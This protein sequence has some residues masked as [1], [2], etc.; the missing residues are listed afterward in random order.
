MIRRNR[1]SELHLP[2]LR[3]A[4]MFVEFDKKEKELTSIEKTYTLE[5]KIN[6]VNDP[7][8][9]I[10]RTKD[11]KLLIASKG[12]R[13][14]TSEIIQLTDEDDRPDRVKVQVVEANGVHVAVHGQKVNEFT[15][16]QLIDEVVSIVDEG[17]VEMGSIRLLARDG[18]SRS[19][20]LTVKTRSTQV[21][22]KLVS[23]TGLKLLHHSSATITKRNLS[24]EA[25]IR[26]MIVSYRIVDLPDTGVVECRVEGESEFSMCTSFSQS[27]INDEEVR[28][29][30]TS[31]ASSPSDMFS[32]Q[33]EAGEYASM[34]HVFRI[35]FIPMNVKVFTREPFVLN[36]TEVATIGRQN[37]FAWTFP[38]S[39]SSHNLIYFI[40]EPPKLGTLSRRIG[41]TKKQRRI[42]VSSNFTQQ[43]IDEGSISYKLHYQQYSIVND[44][45]MFRVVSPAVSSALLRFEIVY[46]PQA[47]S[48]RLINKTIVVKE[49]E[50]A[51]VTPD[52]LS[53]STPD[54]SDFV[55]RVITP[56]VHGTLRLRDAFLMTIL[57]KDSNFT[58]NDLMKHRLVYTHSDDESRSDECRLLAISSQNAQ[59]Q[60]PLILS[61]SIILLNDNAPSVSK[62]VTLYMVERGERVLHDFL[63]PWKDDDVDT[64]ALLFDFAQNKDAAILST[65]S[66]YLP[67]TSFSQHEID[68]GKVMIR[69]LG[70][71]SEFDIN[72]TVSDGVHRVDGRMHVV[73]E[74]PKVWVQH[75]EAIVTCG[76]TMPQIIRLTSKNLTVLTNLDVRL[77]DIV[78]S[79]NSTRF[80]IGANR[81]VVST[82]TQKDIDAELVWY[83]VASENELESLN[84]AIA[85]RHLDVQFVVRCVATQGAYDYQQHQVLRVPMGGATLID[86]TVLG[87]FLNEHLIYQVVRQPSNGYL[88]LDEKSFS[89]RVSRFTTSDVKN[90]R[91]QYVHNNAN[92]MNDSIDFQIQTQTNGI[93]LL[94]TLDID[95]FVRNVSMTTRPFTVPAG[96]RAP[97]TPE[98]LN[99]TTSENDEDAV[100]SVISPPT[101]GWITT[102]SLKNVSN[103]NSI[104]SFTS[105]MLA[106]GH[107]WF[108][109]DGSE[110][111]DSIAVRAC[112]QDQCTGAQLLQIIVN[113]INV[114]GPVLIR[115]EVL[116]V[117]GE[118]ALITNLHLNVKDEDTP[119]N[120]I[121]YLISPPSNGK[122]VKMPHTQEAITNFTQ[123]DI[124]QSHVVFLSS[125]NSNPFGGFSFH[126]SDGIQKIGPEWFST[127]LSSSSNI[128]EANGRLVASPDSAVV[129]G[130][131]LLRANMPGTKPEEIVFTILK[132]PKY[133]ELLIDGIKGNIFTQTQI[134]RRQVVYSTIGTIQ[135]NEWSRRDSFSF[136]I[137]RNNSKQALN[138]N[139]KFRITTT[140]AALSDKIISKY[141]TTS[142]L[143]VSRGGS[144][145]FNHSHLDVSSL[146]DTVDKEV[147]MI[148]IGTEPRH[149]RLEWLDNERKR[150]S[151]TE[152][153]SAFFL[154]YQHNDQDVGDDSLVFHVYAAR[155]STRRASRIRVSVMIK[156]RTPP[157]PNVQV[158]LFPSSVSILNS[159]STP[160]L[161]DMLMT[162]HKSVP[163][164]SIVYRTI[165][166]GANGVT[167]RKNDDEVKMFTQN[168]I[169]EG[170]IALWHTSSRHQS[171]SW[172]DV[173]VV[174]I[175]GHT[176]TIVVDIKP[177]DLT[178]KNHSTIWYPQGKT[179]VVLSSRHLGAFSNG[180]REM[181][182]YKITS[183]PENG[184]FYWVAGEKEAK[185]FT[186]KDI[187]E[188]RILYAQLNMHSYQDRFEFVVENDSRD[189]LR[190]SSQL[191]V[192]AL[193]AVQPVIVEADTATP[194]TSSQINASALMNSSPRFF[195]TS[196]LKYGRL[197]FDPNTNYTTYY[198]TYSDIQKGIV[199]YKA[200]K[201]D[202]E[203]HEI[204]NL[205]V[206]ADN[207]Q[208]ARFSLPITI[209]RA[210]LEPIE[211]ITT[212]EENEVGGERAKFA[213]FG[214]NSVP[215][216]ILGAILAATLFILLCRRCENDKKKKKKKKKT[217][218][219]LNTQL[220]TPT[221]LPPSPTASMERV[222]KPAD[223]LG[224]TVFASVRQAEDRM[225][226]QSFNK[227]P[228]SQEEVHRKPVGGVGA[229][230]RRQ[231]V[232][233]LDYAGIS[234]DTPPPMR[235]FDQVANTQPANHYWV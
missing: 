46:V 159:G 138:S 44:F 161:A 164:Q 187:D 148:E 40:D 151:W 105:K 68:E 229:V 176:R 133:G 183:G 231:N 93:P 112:V 38:K 234:S 175:E 191:M 177:L 145:C 196:Q 56:T 33:V 88:L 203:V 214:E 207:V 48:I 23:N 202:E 54:D 28:F 87:E 223:L 166:R 81:R 7:P 228:K 94:F 156:V 58:T 158:V 49:G 131:E 199:Y 162:R 123:F 189:V 113:Q 198:F 45:F 204:V 108:V 118:K 194:L 12:S 226:M 79:S 179:Y 91:V 233:S 4:K 86:H 122:I 111:N 97:I 78:Y 71:H 57:K 20:V 95:V 128:L 114:K 141:I 186:Q 35:D 188:G 51:S 213:P 60:V 63:L 36:G 77:V 168:E 30:H 167:I 107:V 64:P 2:R 11:E 14:L 181:L 1:L 39:F 155:E 9:L 212:I 157:D 219:I 149:G 115:N 192:R 200:F 16:K 215:V 17:D 165:Q 3:R 83:T 153:R 62:N 22:V 235:L 221:R 59:R 206:R 31:S 50:S 195:L 209:L 32:F 75:S 220:D 42:G 180:N 15:H 76:S 135:Q 82:F 116:R 85:D 130:A 140:Y 178:L 139:E 10:K 53:L 184:T 117:S 19:N 29:R 150:M 43:D 137:H 102:H 21:D 25:S 152:L 174:D 185:E 26:D 74:K 106:A 227:P 89:S 70:H 232:S 66:P 96:G 225:A 69:H 104:D 119:S 193:V 132:P 144:A 73:A 230:A 172:H 109:S 8:E 208:P 65:V 18:D 146:V 67:L 120:S 125:N 99:V 92:S 129:I 110:G 224:T 217:V 55:F 5:I 142:P 222:E 170:K 210:D 90:G 201:T 143:I 134:N 124:D 100:I 182:K 37:L 197:T 154:I 101:S 98:V 52:F 126:V 136:K 121:I 103:I 173:I 127:E 84:V 169:N 13:V 80:F 160:L 147:V 34:V 27:Q 163:P 205:E 171:V 72:Y 61:F 41:A 211:P 218:Q 190:N 6:G 216:W 47:S 24:F